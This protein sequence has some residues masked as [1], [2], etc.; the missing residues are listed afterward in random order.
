MASDKKDKKKTKWSVRWR[1]KYRLVFMTDDTL[2]ERFT[3]RLSRLNV[4]VA[5]GTLTIV[6]IF[7][8]SILIAFTPLR[9]YIPGYT[10]VGLTKKLYRLQMRTDSIERDLEMKDRFI[11][12]LKDIVEGKDL[13]GEIR[14][15]KDTMKRYGDIKIKRSEEDSLLRLE[16]DNQGKYALYNMEKLETA[17]QKKSSLGSVLFFSPLKGVITNGFNLV[18]KHYGVDIVAKQD[19][20]IKAVLDGTVIFSTWTLE[21][22]YVIAIQHGQNIISLYKHN[23][24]LLKKTG[25][26]VKAGEPIAIVGQTGELI[27]GPHLH[28]ELWSDGNP[29][30]PKEYIIF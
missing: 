8:T 5:L 22:G 26:F 21:T 20:T 7:L 2:E 3:F 29:V 15:T 25:D 14:P 16:V 11:Q 17:G 12:N 27:T 19:E 23:A 18:Q 4:F 24:A 30:D 28:F 13:P 10:N 9:E 6:L 1:N